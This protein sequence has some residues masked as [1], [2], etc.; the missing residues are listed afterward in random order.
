MLIIVTVVLR[1]LVDTLLAGI[2]L[3]DI[4]ASCGGNKPS[5]SKQG[6]EETY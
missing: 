3:T 1:L 4:P 2:L 6:G 5:N